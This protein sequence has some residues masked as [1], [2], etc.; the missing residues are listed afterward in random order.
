M[1]R[2]YYH[3]NIDGIEVYRYPSFHVPRLVSDGQKL[4]LNPGILWHIAREKFDV[5]HVHGMTP[6]TT[7]LSVLV[8]KARQKPVVLTYHY[9]VVASKGFISMLKPI[10]QRYARNVI[11]KA[12]IVTILSSTYGRT[13]PVLSCIDRGKIVAIPGGVDLN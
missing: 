7:D 11:N 2:G 1:P 3:Q 5:L 10:F 8:G 9:D 12:D 13:S 4:P 6:G